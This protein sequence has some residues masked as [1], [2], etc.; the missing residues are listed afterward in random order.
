MRKLSSK[1]HIMKTVLS[2]IV[3]LIKCSRHRG[4]RP[5]P[6]VV[7]VSLAMYFTLT[8]VSRANAADFNLTVGVSLDGVGGIPVMTGDF[9]YL[10]TEGFLS[11]EC[12]AHPQG[13]D[14]EFG[15][16]SSIFSDA[17]GANLSS[18]DYAFSGADSPS[19]MG[20]SRS[21]LYAARIAFI[22]GSLGGVHR[23]NV[24]AAAPSG[25]AVKVLC[26]ETTL[27]G[28]FNT[29]GTMYNFLELVYQPSGFAEKVY[30][31][32]FDSSGSLLL[33][34]RVINLSSAGR[35][36]VDI[37]SL[38]GPNTFG[39]LLITHLKPYKEIRG[40]V[41]RYAPGTSSAEPLILRGQSPLRTRGE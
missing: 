8:L 1:E 36:D 10:N 35:T 2:G 30:L 11:Y 22:S 17:A 39:K 9:F 37:H 19:I 32:A 29:N 31:S 38:V 34:N 25:E 4:Q 23:L 21:V 14:S 18:G 13:S 33:N 16:S 3:A 12:S 15:F 6:S 27:Y 26:R 20:T 7:I 41:S 24:A 5:S 40:F 28:E